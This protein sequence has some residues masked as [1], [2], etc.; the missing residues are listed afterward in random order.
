MLI[1]GF[2]MEDVGYGIKVT[3]H[4]SGWSFWLQ[5]DD[6]QLFRDD[7]KDAEDVGVNFRHF[8]RYY[9]YTAMLS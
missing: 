8:L 9:D 6:A 5:G 3:E 4:E 7:W 1:G 2:Q